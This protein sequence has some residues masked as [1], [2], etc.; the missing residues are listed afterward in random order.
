MDSLRK[1]D[2]FPGRRTRTTSTV[3]CS[4]PQKYDLNAFITAAKEAAM[5]LVSYHSLF[6]ISFVILYVCS[7]IFNS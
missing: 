4:V 7:E 6:R 2:S 3:I 5:Y 1:S